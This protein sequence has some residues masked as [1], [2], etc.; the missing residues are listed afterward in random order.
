MASMVLIY[1]GLILTEKKII[2][3][4]FEGVSLGGNVRLILLLLM[5]LLGG[6]L[7]LV[8]VIKS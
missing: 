5:V 7:L 8:K 2:F 4:F 1:P 6:L 3:S